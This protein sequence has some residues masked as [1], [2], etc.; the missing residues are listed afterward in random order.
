V[1][2]DRKKDALDDHHHHRYTPIIFHGLWSLRE[3]E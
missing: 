2:R 1:E 3:E